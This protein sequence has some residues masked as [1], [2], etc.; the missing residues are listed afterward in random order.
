MNEK[1][2]YC[3][4]ILTST[5]HT[6]LEPW[7]K[8]LHETSNFVVTSTVGALVEGW[9]LIISKRHVP[10]MGALTEVELSELQQLVI[11]VRN[12]MESHYGFVVMFEHGPACEG[13]AFGCGIDHAHLHVVPLQ[14]TLAPLV[15][16]EL[17][18]HIMWE[19]IADV[20]NLSQI[21][22]QRVSYLYILEN[23]RSEGK[24]IRLQNIPSQ[25]MRRVIA[26]Y[27]GI[28]HLYDYRRYK[29][30]QNVVAALQRLETV[31]NEETASLVGAK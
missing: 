26:N 28:P 11:K 17:Q 15:E 6:Q 9:T 2:A 1:C 14:I 5:A 20:R 29:F 30:R 13:T 16:H 27:L 4:N 21:H 24:V 19:T 8:I 10:A 18:F 7:D 23:S 22:Q 12:L 3:S 31:Y 25:F